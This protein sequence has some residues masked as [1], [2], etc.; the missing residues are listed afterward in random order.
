[1][2]KDKDWEKIKAEAG[3]FLQ[4]SRKYV[5]EYVAEVKGAADAAGSGIGGPFSLRLRR[6][7]IVRI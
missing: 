1:M 3:L 5:P 7:R 4:Y 6:D 2:K